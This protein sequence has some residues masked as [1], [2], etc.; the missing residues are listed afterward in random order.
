MSK[1]KLS[2]TLQIPVKEAEQLIADY[3]KAFPKIKQLLS[4]LGRFGVEKGYIHTI[5]PYFRRRSFPYW[6]LSKPFIEEH[7]SGITYNATLGS[8]ERQSMNQPIQGAGSNSIKLAMWLVY[9]WQRDN[10]YTDRI[11]T[12]LNIHDELATV[13]EDSLTEMWTVQLNE[14][15]LEAGRVIVP[16]GILKADTA[17]SGKSW[18]K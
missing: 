14:L 6:N 17:S 18:T 8:I 15:M 7:L 12:L 4:F 13:C 9:K 5:G 2:S 16:S 1:F 10:G 11:C 3:F